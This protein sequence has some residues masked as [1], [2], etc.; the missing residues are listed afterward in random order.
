MSLVIPGAA[1]RARWHGALEARTRR[2]PLERFLRTRSLKV[3]PPGSAQDTD[4]LARAATYFVNT[5]C[6]ACADAHP[7]KALTRRQSAILAEM[8][9]AIATG[10]ATLI[11]RREHSQVVAAVAV[12][13][14][15]APRVA[16]GSAVDLAAE[17]EVHYQARAQSPVL[18][19]L[20]D[21][22]ESQAVLAV[23]HD[24]EVHAANVAGLMAQRLSTDQH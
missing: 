5:A 3:S 1:I 11:G 16:G 13:T 24:D 2:I 6:A 10:L 7:K 23:S 4:N 21:L 9:C 20:L 22:I 14:F 19:M 8:T 12:T 17:A 18:D 15:F